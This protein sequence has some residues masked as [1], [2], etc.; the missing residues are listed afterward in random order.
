M[1]KIKVKLNRAEVRKQI[2]QNPELEAICRAAGERAANLSGLRIEYSIVTDNQR[3]KVEREMSKKEQR[4]EQRAV[5]KRHRKK[6][7]KIGKYMK[8][9][10][11]AEHGGKT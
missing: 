6:N 4:R 5:Q 8:K 3:I 9:K 10:W 1:A 11:A 2:L 7:K